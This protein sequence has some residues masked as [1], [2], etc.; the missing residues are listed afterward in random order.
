MES[1]SHK[2]WLPYNCQHKTRLNLNNPFKRSQSLRRIIMWCFCLKPKHCFT[3]C[4]RWVLWQ[5][6]RFP[7]SPAFKAL[8][9][10]FLGVPALWP[11]VSPEKDSHPFLSFL[12]LYLLWVRDSDPLSYSKNKLKDQQLEPGALRPLVHLWILK[13]E[14]INGEKTLSCKTISMH[15]IYIQY[16]Y[17]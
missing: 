3:F 14:V 7:S 4:L 9:G 16:I 15:C 13:W 2:S 5:T 11:L 6:G 12:S 1:E 10:L 8:A 17:V